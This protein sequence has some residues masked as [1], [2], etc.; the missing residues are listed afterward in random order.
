MRMNFFPKDFVPTCGSFKFLSSIHAI[1]FWSCFSKNFKSYK[2][3]HGVGKSTSK[4]KCSNHSTAWSWTVQHLIESKEQNRYDFHEK[5][6]KQND[7]DLSEWHLKH[8]KNV[9]LHRFW[10]KYMKLIKNKKLFYWVNISLAMMFTVDVNNFTITWL[11]S[12]KWLALWKCFC[13]KGRPGKADEQ[14]RV[15]KKLEKLVELRDGWTVT[16]LIARP[17]LPVFFTLFCSFTIRGRPLVYIKSHF[18][19]NGWWNSMTN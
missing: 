11:N 16:H 10:W 6:R 19:W 12:N 1:N 9:E 8:F 17:A 4:N 7:I 13:I 15:Q 14:R 3:C 18:T 5:F 2:L